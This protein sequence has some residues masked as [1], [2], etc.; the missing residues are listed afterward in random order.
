VIGYMKEMKSKKDL[1][2]EIKKKIVGKKIVDIVVDG[3][4]EVRGNLLECDMGE[5]Y[6]VLEDGTIISAWNSEWGGIEIKKKEEIEKERVDVR[7]A[8][9]NIVNSLIKF[10]ALHHGLN[11]KVLHEIANKIK[12]ST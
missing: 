10:H 6:L 5:V 11:E 4:Y 7:T 9:S 3:E 12:D 2:E 1:L 8:I